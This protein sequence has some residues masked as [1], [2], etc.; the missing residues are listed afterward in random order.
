VQTNPDR[1]GSA[2]LP[3]REWPMPVFAEPPQNPEPLVTIPP[4]LPIEESVRACWDLT[5]DAGYGFGGHIQRGQVISI[6][7]PIVREMPHAFETLPRP[8]TPADFEEVKD[9]G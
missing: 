2:Q 8:L 1:F 9:D 5:T 3:Q 4:Q 6:R 7:Q